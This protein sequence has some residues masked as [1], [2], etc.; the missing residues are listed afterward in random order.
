MKVQFVTGKLAAPLLRETVQAL[1]ASFES[2]VS[3]LGISVAALMTTDW[4][5][6]FLK[7]EP[8]VELVLLP[9]HA[10]GEV[11]ALEERLGVRV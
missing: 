3:E 10:Q 8:G 2:T 11:G 9:G 5:G 4:V 6:R 1:P 7:V